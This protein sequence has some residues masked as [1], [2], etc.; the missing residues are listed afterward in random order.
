MNGGKWILG[1]ASSNAFL[2]DAATGET[3]AAFSGHES[4]INFADLSSDSSLVVTTSRDG[5]AR[6]LDAVSG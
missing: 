6:A 2:G 3:I 1:S 4:E 5:T